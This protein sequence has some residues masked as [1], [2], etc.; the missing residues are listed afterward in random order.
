[1]DEFGQNPRTRD[2]Q[3]I[4][5][6]L[7]KYEVRGEWR[8]AMH[9]VEAA[10]ADEALYKRE[11]KKCFNGNSELSPALIVQVRMFILSL[12]WQLG[13]FLNLH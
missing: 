12:R 6:T 10:Q 4:L 8:L 5:Q 13:M 9:V 11:C 7:E 3:I 1:M 2:A